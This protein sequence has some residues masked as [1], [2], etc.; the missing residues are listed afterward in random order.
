MKFI[1][2]CL[3]EHLVCIL[4][5][6]QFVRASTTLLSHGLSA[7]HSCNCAYSSV[8]WALCICMMSLV[9]PWMSSQSGQ[10][11]QSTPSLLL[12]GPLASNHF[13]LMASATTLV[14]PG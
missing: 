6:S 4:G 7:N 11:D 10:M 13:L 12:L 3:A 8:S 14:T 2:Q 5:M 9:I 1:T